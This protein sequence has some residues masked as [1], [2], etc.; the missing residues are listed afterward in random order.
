MQSAA[1]SLKHHLA[2][3]ANVFRRVDLSQQLGFFGGTWR[4]QFRALKHLNAACGA[5]SR[6][7]AEGKWGPRLIADVEQPLPVLR[8]DQNGPSELA[9]HELN[10]CHR[11]W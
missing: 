6:A 5:A 4:K 11:L 3:E 1:S 2:A 9:L 7:T 10:L 8:R